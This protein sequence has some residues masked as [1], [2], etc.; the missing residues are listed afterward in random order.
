MDK[1]IIKLPDVDCLNCK[2]KG[3]CVTNP[4]YIVTVDNI[5]VRPI[6]CFKCKTHW[7]DFYG[8]SN[9]SSP[10]LSIQ[11]NSNSNSNEQTDK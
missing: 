8:D 4:N 5:I 7:K 11:R 10:V 2:E 1:D 6:V 3:Y 9:D